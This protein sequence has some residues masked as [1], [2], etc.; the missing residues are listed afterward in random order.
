MS[1]VLTHIAG[2]DV[3][4]GQHLRQ[5]CAWCGAV[6]IDADLTAVAVSIPEG[7]TAEQARADGDLNYPTWKVGAL[8]SRTD[9]GG[10]SYVEHSDGDQ[11]PADACAWLPHEVTA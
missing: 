2:L 10:V 3:Q 8:V 7:K 5:R 6:L 4:V 1:D 9:G 11:L